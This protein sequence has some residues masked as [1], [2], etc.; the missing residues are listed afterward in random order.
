MKVNKL[1]DFGYAFRIKLIAALFRDKLFLQQIIDILDSNYF[2]SESNIVILDII[3]EYFYEFKSTPTLEAMKIKI[4]EMDNDLLKKSIAENI[5]AAFANLEAE[6]LDFVKQKALEFC[7]NQEIKKAILESVELLNNGQYDE[8]KAKVDNA[9]KAG[10]EKDMGHEYAEHI[11]ERYLDSVRNTVTT[12]WDAIDDIADGGLGKGEL[13][14]M[15]APAGIGKSWA[16]V[17]VGAAAVRSGLTVIHYTLELNA[18][19][20]GL[21]YDSVFTG[22]Q[23]QELKYSIDDVK[24]KV[25]TLKGDLVVKYYP[26]KSATVN[27]IAAHIQRCTALGKKPDLVIV[28]YAD[29][30]RGHGKEVRLELGNIY[31]DLRGLA[32]ECEIPIWTASQANRSALEDDIIGAEKIAESYSKIMTADFVLSLSR[33]IEDKLANTGRWHVI[34]NRFGPDGITFPSKMNASNGQNELIY[35][36]IDIY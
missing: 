6:D 5:K 32:G 12:G 8:I 25:A 23:A 26:T 33:K 20:V 21:R 14:V 27:T 28:D 15:V 17:N 10:V 1:S 13:G 2:D 3:K 29:L 35:V 19:Y 36:Y 30:L 18:A 34:K 24:K 7:K 31:E 22:I 9:M 16:L 4:V 11:D